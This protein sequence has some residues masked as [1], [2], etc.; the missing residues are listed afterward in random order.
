MSARLP[1]KHTRVRQALLA[2]LTRRLGPKEPGTRHAV[3]GF[4]AGGPPDLWQF[5]Q[6]KDLPG[7]TYVTCELLTCE[8]QIPSAI[9]RYEVALT[10]PTADPWAEHVLHELAQAS[11]QSPINIGHTLDIARWVEP[12]CGIQGLFVTRL[13]SFQLDGASYGVLFFVGVTRAE[14]DFARSAEERNEVALRLHAAG[15]FPVTQV[16]RESV[17]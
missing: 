6:A 4:E 5:C 16:R 8:R 1:D 9:G 12:D 7:V 3:I 17:V 11:R 15:G 14:L 13:L 10:V 2:G